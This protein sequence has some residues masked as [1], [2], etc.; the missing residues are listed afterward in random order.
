MA[1]M[2]GKSFLLTKKIG[3]LA[4]VRAQTTTQTKTGVLVVRLKRY[5]SGQAMTKNL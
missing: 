2:I 1:K 5:H 4:R 3:R